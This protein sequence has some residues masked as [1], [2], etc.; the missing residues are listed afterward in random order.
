MSELACAAAQ[1]IV[2]DAHRDSTQI[3]R[4]SARLLI[5]FSC[6]LKKAEQKDGKIRCSFVTKKSERHVPRS[7]IMRETLIL[8]AD[9]KSLVSPDSVYVSE[10]CPS[11]VCDVRDE[12]SR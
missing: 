2:D 5:H 4:F 12:T 8:V 7:R 3:N 9:S 11:S 1:I 6:R 10:C